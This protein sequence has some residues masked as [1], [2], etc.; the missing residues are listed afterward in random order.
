W[1]DTMNAQGTCNPLNL[2]VAGTPTDVVSNNDGI[3]MVPMHVRVSSLTLVE[4]P[5]SSGIYNIGI[6][7]AYG[8]NDLVNTA[9]N[10]VSC[11]G[12][13]G[14]QYCAVSHIRDTVIRRVQ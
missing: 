10:P 5:P 4:A 8:D 13:T 2:T 9:T 7:L 14:T 12:S 6:A 3:E 11:R 1:K